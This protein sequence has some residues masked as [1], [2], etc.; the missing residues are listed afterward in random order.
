MRTEQELRL[1]PFT[2]LATI[3]V[4]LA[5]SAGFTYTCVYSDSS[6]ELIIHGLYSVCVSL[7]PIVLLAVIW[8]KEAKKPF[9]IHARRIAWRA[10]FYSY[11]AIMT[12]VVLLAVFLKTTEIERWKFIIWWTIFGPPMGFIL[13]RLTKTKERT[14]G[15]SHK[16]E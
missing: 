12:G 2:Y 1:Q 15:H 4:I 14:T 8:K 16:Q 6:R 10:M 3:P 13:Y 9:S 11:L 5:V 7:P